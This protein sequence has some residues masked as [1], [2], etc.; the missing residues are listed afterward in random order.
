MN[1]AGIGRR[2]ALRALI[3]LPAVALLPLTASYTAT[4]I[5]T[6]SA[7]DLPTGSAG[8][9]DLGSRPAPDW[10][11]DIAD[12]CSLTALSVPGSHDTMAYRGT[13]LAQ[14]QSS[15]LPTQLAAG[16][17]AIDIRT[18]HFR[19]GFPI[20][21]GIEYLHADF[22]DVVRQLSAFL[23]AHPGEAILMRL[24]EESTPAENT[25]SYEAT[26]NWYI[27]QNPQTRDLLSAYLWKPPTGYDGS[28]PALGEVRGKIVVLQ[29]FSA[30]NVYGPR[31]DGA[32]MDI[33]DDY[34]LASLADVPSK[35]DSVSRQFD[36]ARGGSAQT[37]FI[38]HLS[39]TGTDPLA[40][41]QGTVP[42]TVARGA[43]GVVGIL[44]RTR[45]H[46]SSDPTGRTGVVMADFP[47]TAIVGA[48]IA[49][50]TP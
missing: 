41:A 10:M 49:R 16:V 13:I 23:R 33:Q 1:T 14:T 3:T 40:I 31:W 35:W 42:V 48:V 27:H 9:D 26:L 50:N 5:T 43:P 34:E 47:T 19:D 2:S 4:A 32:H 24:K 8:G 20:H 36:A 11:K 44:E 30:S 45:G 18:R 7:D 29:D 15:D 28:I 38:N 25:R 39:A 21:H 12:A 46:L 17:R 6:G 22:T 37:L